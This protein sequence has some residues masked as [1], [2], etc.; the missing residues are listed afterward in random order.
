MK[1]TIL[2]EYSS[3]LIHVDSNV[4]AYIWLFVWI[5]DYCSQT[6]EGVL[7]I[8][9]FRDHNICVYSMSSVLRY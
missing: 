2:K 6:V 3:V 9:V 4:A 7:H 5:W 1:L 8:Q